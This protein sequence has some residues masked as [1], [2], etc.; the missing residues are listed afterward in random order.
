MRILGRVVLVLVAL[1][2]LFCSS[3][4]GSIK[5]FYQDEYLAEDGVYHNKTIGFSI[6]YMGN[7]HLITDPADMTGPSL[8]LARDLNASGAEL[9]YI[10]ATI[11]A[12]QGTRA[13][14]VN[15]NEDPEIY[16]DSVR[17]YNREGI[18]EEFG[19][20]TML[21]NDKPMV[22]WE[23]RIGEFRFVEFIFAVRTYNVRIA[24]WSRPAVYN[25]FLTVYEEIMA[26]LTQGSSLR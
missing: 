20:T 9:L 26:T 1:A 14:A 25:N 8:S 11:D 4:A 18:D 2:L 10:G 6:L 19:V 24:F 16:T 13:I 12:T 17:S 22:K 5:Q 15:L 21:I 7:W 23:Y 3:C